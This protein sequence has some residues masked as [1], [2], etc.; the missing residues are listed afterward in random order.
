MTLS[1][2]YLLFLGDAPAANHAKTAFGLKDWAPELCIGEY[3]CGTAVSIGLPVMTPD[4]AH[5]R[6][7]RSMVI[8]VVNLGGFIPDSWIA[9]LVRAMEAGLDIVSGMHGRL[10]DRAELADAASRLGRR[11]VDVRIPPAGIPIANGRKRSG[12]RLLTV[13]TDCALGKKYTALALTRAFR[14]RGLAADFRATGQTGIMIAGS[15]VPIDAVVSDFV[16]GAA[17]MISP[18]ASADHWDVIEGQGSI[19]H[20]SYA[21]VSLGLLH[22]SQPDVIVVCHEPG[23][24]SMAGLP[25]FAVPD[26]SEVMELCLALGGRTNPAIRCGGISMNSSALGADEARRLMTKESARLGLPVA[27]PIRGGEAFD[28]LV[29][30]CLRT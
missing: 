10:S 24:T 22:G 30:A 23:R 18:E 14:A 8:G 16:A 9:P 28:A 17:E 29:D 2:P 4:E 5:E 21:G 7:A 6:G 11:L 25:D 19:L 27:D 13:G 20:P 1:P 15:G 12:R 3:G 26:I